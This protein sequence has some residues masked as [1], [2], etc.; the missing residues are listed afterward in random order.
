[1]TQ[2]QKRA[3]ERML[4]FLPVK[5]HRQPDAVLIGKQGR[6]ITSEQRSRVQFLLKQGGMT[7]ELIAEDAGCAISTVFGIKKAM[8]L[9]E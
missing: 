7:L 5:T 9:G 4:S 3:H 8:R 1:M 2:E 6:H